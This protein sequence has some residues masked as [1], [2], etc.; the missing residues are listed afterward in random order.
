MGMNLDGPIYLQRKGML[1]ERNMVLDIGPQT[2]YFALAEQIR[3]FVKTKEA[4]PL[5]RKA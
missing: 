3:E 2:I 1:R 5:R 4:R